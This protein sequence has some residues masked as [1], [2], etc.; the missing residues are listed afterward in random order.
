[1]KK[2]SIIFFAVCSF[3]VAS[4]QQLF[5]FGNSETSKAE[6]LR[7]Y[8]KNKP[9]TS[10]KEKSMR[11]YLE[12][13]TNFKLKVKAAQEMRLDTISQIRYDIQNFRDQVIDNY[14]ND[15]E[16]MQIL[17]NE[18]IDRAA[19]DIQ[20]HYFSVPVLANALPADTL[21]AYNAAMELNNALKK[22][23]TTDYAEMVTNIS[24]KSFPVKFADIGFQTAFA[25]PYEYEN[26]IYNTAVGEVS[27]PYRSSKGWVIFKIVGQRPAVGTWKVAQL[28]FAYPPNADYDA[29]MK[30]KQKADSVFALLKAGLM[31]SEAATTYSDDRM[32]NMGGGELPE[33]G[34]GKYNSVFEKNVFELQKDND[35]TNPFETN[36]GYHIVKRLGNTAIPTDRNDA[37]Y[38]FII[39]Q[40]VSQDTRI[41][42]EK[43]KFA[44]DITAKTG[45]K[46]VAAITNEMLFSTADSLMKDPSEAKIASLPISKKAILGFKDG[47]QLKGS[48]WLKY[49]RD[50]KSNPEAVSVENKALF[51]KFFEKA[52]LDY[53]KKHLEEYNNE[54]KYQMQEFKEGNLLFEIMERNVW[55]KAGADSIG[56]RRYFEANKQNYKWGASADVLVFNCANEIAA[57]KA[58]EDCKN[59]IPWNTIAQES[60]NQIQADSGRNEMSQIIDSLSNGKPGIGSYSHFT[61]NTDGSATFVKYIKLYEAG[62][63]RS[64]SEARGLVINDYQNVLEKQWVDNLRKKYTVK[65]NEATF[66]EMLK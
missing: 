3:C 49:V 17:V 47:T 43:E 27:P 40:K 53:Y 39:K 36:F 19:K 7:A 2:F 48:D 52:V 26:M 64:F 6:F 55:S 59:G 25:L 4:A 45:I 61:I 29:K 1:M 28:L 30:V 16:G 44:K 54:F 14:L 11:E 65:Y 62:M 63:Q 24:A 15:D 21:K 35:I 32:T 12:L 23:K 57:K 5:T 56:L 9:S 46:R 42:K 33:F 13:Y 60:N 58:L 34:S 31:F 22:N 18:A 38:Q 51:G 66:R 10:D 20:V 41:N 37:A 50:C 8:N